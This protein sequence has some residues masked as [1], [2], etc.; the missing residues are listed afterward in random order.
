MSVSHFTFSRPAA[1][2]S[3]SDRTCKL[4]GIKGTFKQAVLKAYELS[5]RE[6]ATITIM[7]HDNNLSVG[8]VSHISLQQRI[9]VRLMVDLQVSGNSFEELIT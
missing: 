6:A 3:Y 5:K 8:L 9:G 7:D 4:G 2:Q 1:N